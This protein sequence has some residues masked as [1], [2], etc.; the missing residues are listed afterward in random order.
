M[1]LLIYL[2]KLLSLCDSYKILVINP[3]FAYSH[4]NFMG[5]IADTLVDAG[6]EVVSSF[7]IIFYY[8]RGSF[9]KELQ[10]HNVYGRWT[11]AYSSNGEITPCKDQ[12]IASVESP[13]TR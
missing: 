6:H 13:F 3:K 12:L 4:M 7:V 1:I 11:D 9:S 2:F 10:V 5:K 8:M